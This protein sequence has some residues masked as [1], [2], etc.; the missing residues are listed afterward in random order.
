MFLIVLWLALFVVGANLI[1][2]AARAIRN[3][4]LVAFGNALDGD[5]AVAIGALMVVGGVTLAPPIVLLT[6]FMFTWRPWGGF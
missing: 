4:Q 6:S 2:Y 3:R 5:W 1:L